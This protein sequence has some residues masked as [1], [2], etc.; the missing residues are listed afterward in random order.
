MEYDLFSLQLFLPTPF[1]WIHFSPY[2]WT[3][4]TLHVS[5]SLCF[6][7]FFLYFLQDETPWFLID[8]FLYNIFW[9][10]YPFWHKDVCY[11]D[12][13]R[14]IW[15]QFICPCWII[16]AVFL[17]SEKVQPFF[18]FHSV[19][20]W[21]TFVISSAHCILILRLETM[22]DLVY[23]NYRGSD[24]ICV[25]T[26]AALVILTKNGLCYQILIVIRISLFTV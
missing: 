25:Y 2:I 1:W 10:D 24:N 17:I 15:S 22:S 19:K 16:V 5:F 7:F 8:W 21:H 3:C 13:L 4:L 11:V 18:L 9:Y 12:F 14:P 26:E 20:A 6:F 23:L